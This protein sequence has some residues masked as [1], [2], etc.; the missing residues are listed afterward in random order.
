M[1]NKRSSI[2]NSLTSNKS[3]CSHIE[4]TRDHQGIPLY[5]LDPMWRML[6]QHLCTS[7]CLPELW[8]FRGPFWALSQQ[9]FWPI[10]LLEE[11]VC[12]LTLLDLNTSVAL[13]SLANAKLQLWE[14]RLY[15]QSI[16]ERNA[17]VPKLMNNIYIHPAS[18]HM[19]NHCC[20]YAS[21]P[22]DS[23]LFLE[24]QVFHMRN[25]T[26][27][28]KKIGNMG[29]PRDGKWSI[30]PRK[31]F[32]NLPWLE[33][34]GNLIHLMLNHFP[35]NCWRSCCL[36]SG[37][38]MF[39]PFQTNTLC[40][41]CCVLTQAEVPTCTNKKPLCNW[42]AWCDWL[43]LFESQCAGQSHVSRQFPAL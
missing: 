36:E 3:K 5:I 39:K 1:H 29:V 9:P 30:P 19:P 23:L 43:S 22:F 10:D 40:E 21:N 15:F 41:L 37:L 7:L 11:P 2:G 38:S 4:D 13:H 35:S 24:N 42:G 34:N 17:K 33:K 31:A 25:I 32:W 12:W 26:I 27:C 18:L 16:L 8:L 28:W 14:D 6:V 20:P